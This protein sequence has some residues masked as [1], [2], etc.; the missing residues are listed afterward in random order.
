MGLHS[1]QNIVKR[2]NSRDHFRAF[3]EHH[4][5]GTDAHRGI[6]YFRPRG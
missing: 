5:L 2:P 1:P 4:A 6:S 3:V